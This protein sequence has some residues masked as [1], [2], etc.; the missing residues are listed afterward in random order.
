MRIECD[1]YVAIIE[2]VK[3]TN[4]HDRVRFHYSITR[5]S[6]SPMLLVSGSAPTEA[7]ARGLVRQ[8]LLKFAA[9]KSELETAQ[10]AAA[11]T[12]R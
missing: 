1:G 7:E 3:V 11:A 2:A 4:R 12:A 8:Y 6:S 10:H 9:M 5:R